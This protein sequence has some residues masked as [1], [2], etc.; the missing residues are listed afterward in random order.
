MLLS[1][2][3]SPLSLDDD[4]FDPIVTSRRDA[5]RFPG[6]VTPPLYP[7]GM[8]R[9]VHTADWQ[10]GMTRHFLA[11]EAQARFSRARVDVIRRIG[12]LATE[13][14]CGFAVVCGDVFE[15][16]QV[17]RPVV[18]QALDAM[19]ATPQ[20]TFYLLPGNHDPLDASSVYRSPTFTEH[21]PGNTVVLEGS[22]PLEVAPGVELIAAPWSTKRPLT[23]LVNDACDGVEAAD[24]V[25]IVVGHGALDSLS[26]D[27]DDPAVISL[28]GLEERL[29]AGQVN[30]VALGDRHSTTGASHTG[31]VWY[32]G[33]P[34]PTDYVENDPGN[35]LVVD[36]DKDHVQVETRPV[37]TWRFLS[38]DR[39]LTG[40]GDIDAID[41]WMSG[42]EGK[43]RTILKMSLVGQVSL[44]QKARLDD[45]LEHHADLLGA[46]ETWERRSELVVIPDGADLDD[47]G[48]SGFA[49]EAVQDLRALAESG[50]QAVAARDALALLYRLV[51]V[52]R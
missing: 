4:T 19:A 23:D 26:P 34:E 47:L 7:P 51:G 52:T 15:S 31:R 14:G 6:A 25:R 17:G 21:Q 38:S 33:A 37:G 41:E 8:V 46:L 50:E 39:E 1:P 44:A 48:L 30:Y 49:Q 40:D 20:V 10:L 12:A 45:L 42:L 13:E 16:N 24:A 43:E 22:S 35:V 29:E 32:S 27:R 36:L 18:V 2:V 5:V 3:G 11:G 9:F 28:P